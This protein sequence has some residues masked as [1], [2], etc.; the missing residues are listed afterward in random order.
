MCHKTGS[1]ID[2]F[3]N[4]FR[5]EWPTLDGIVIIS[6]EYFRADFEGDCFSLNYTQNGSIRLY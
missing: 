3:S 1:K 5:E 6:Q 2:N 4:K